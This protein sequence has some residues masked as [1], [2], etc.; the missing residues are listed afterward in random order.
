MLWLVLAGFSIV[1][2]AHVAPFPFLL[3]RFAPAESLWR[4]ADANGVPPTVYLTFDDGPNP[5]ATPHLLDVLRETGGRGTFFLI[6]DHLTAETAPLVRRMFDEGHAVGLHSDTRALMV[7]TPDVVAAILQEQAAR[8]ELMGGRAPCRLFRPHAGWRGGSML[9][10]LRRID[11]KLVGWGFGLWDFNWYRRP[12][13]AA[14]SARLAK[15]AGAG[16]II[17][18]HDG[19]HVNPRADRHHTV[20][21]VR[22]LVPALRAR[23]L[24]LGTLC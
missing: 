19:H 7:Q 3:E 11:Y 9:Q 4:V 15:R 2:L 12:D 16:D 13:P 6:Y 20:E 14:L 10:A 24:E 1:G 5:E 22:Q 17:V 21:A 23:G 18:L 8:I